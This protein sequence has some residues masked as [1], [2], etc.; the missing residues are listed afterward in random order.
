MWLTSYMAKNIKGK[1]SAS[2]GRVWTA[3]GGSVGIEGSSQ[4]RTVPVVLPYGLY[5]VPPFGQQGVTADTDSGQVFLG[6][7]GAQNRELQPG[8]IMLC[9]K[10]GACIV[11]KNNGQVIINGKVW[12]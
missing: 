7:T 3:Q 2:V 8:E 4:H 5:S 12:E 6:V 9:S 11:L 1:G 10:G